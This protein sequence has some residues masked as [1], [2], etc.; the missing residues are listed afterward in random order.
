[1]A[2][3]KIQ[4]NGNLDYW[5]IPLNGIANP[6]APT[7]AEIAA[8]LRLTPATA[9]DGTTFPNATD[10]NDVDDRSLEDAGNSVDRGYEQMEATST[11]FYPRPENMDD[12]NDPLK[13]AFDAFATPRV[14]GWLVTRVLQRATA[15]GTTP[16]TKGDIV[17]VFKV[18]TDTFTVDTEGEDSYKYTVEFLPQGTMHVH[19]LV[20]GTPALPVVVTGTG[21]TAVG[22]YGTLTATINTVNWTQ[23]VTWLTSN[24]AAATVTPNGV[25]KAV[26][27]GTAEITAEHPGCTPSTAITVTIA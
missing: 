13:I 11:L 25:V 1:M 22:D 20:A 24:P 17:S 12:P 21:P 14:T 3:T 19:T 5:W 10:S 16:A 27:A 18:I 7:E 4:A 9:W 8:G 6:E 26:G 15:P 2:D 23:G